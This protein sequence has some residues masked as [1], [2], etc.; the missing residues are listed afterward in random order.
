[1]AEV[2]VNELRE[3]VTRLKR[4][5]RD[6]E[7]NFNLVVGPHGDVGKAIRELKALTKKLNERLTAVEEALAGHKESKQTK[8][9]NTNN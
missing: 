5:S 9:K 3:Q 6:L 8:T 7:E 4:D 2:E 1:M